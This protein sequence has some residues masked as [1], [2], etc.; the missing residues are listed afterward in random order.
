MYMTS[1]HTGD[2]QGS[3]ADD[4][5]SRDIAG[6]KS[7]SA[8]ACSLKRSWNA[9]SPRA[10]QKKAAADKKG[11]TENKGSGELTPQDAL[12]AVQQRHEETTEGAE[13]TVTDHDHLP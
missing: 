4:T 5:R 10:E 12:A 3:Q 11:S 13:H 9:L 8:S 1:S 2:A 7:A 6:A